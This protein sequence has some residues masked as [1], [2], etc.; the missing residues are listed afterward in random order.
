MSPRARVAPAASPAAAIVLPAARDSTV[1]RSQVI[2]LGELT[3]P[4]AQVP[5]HGFAQESGLK[6]ILFEGLPWRG[7]PTRVFAWPVRRATAST[8][9]PMSRCGTSGCITP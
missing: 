9:I 8:P 5:V 2:A 6:P 4:P 3:I 7:K 1:E